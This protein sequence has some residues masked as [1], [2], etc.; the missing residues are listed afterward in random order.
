M[1]R[2]TGH[3]GRRAKTTT[4]HHTPSAETIGESQVNDT[5]IRK[6]PRVLNKK[7]DGIPEGAVYVGRPTKWG[8]P[9]PI[10]KECS[11]P[12]SIA[13]YKIY[14]VD[15]GL[16]FNVDELRG[17]D[18]VCWCAPLDCHADV[19]LKLA[20]RPGGDQKEKP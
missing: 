8:N 20:N 14:L 15:S 7:H 3:T 5:Q 2:R 12:R 18:L 13:L 19:L 16:I 4:V 1:G 17:R 11:R 9:Y 10:T 6:M